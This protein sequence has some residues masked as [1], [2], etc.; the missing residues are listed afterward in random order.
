MVYVII[1]NSCKL[2][3]LVPRVIQANY[4]ITTF[5]F[6]FLNSLRKSVS[7]EE[8]RWQWPR[9]SIRN[10]SV[11]EGFHRSKEKDCRTHD[12]GTSG[13]RSCSTISISSDSLLCVPDRCQAAPHSRLVNCFSYFCHRPSYTVFKKNRYIFPITHNI[14][15]MFCMIYNFYT[16]KKNFVA[17]WLRNMLFSIQ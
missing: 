1:P 10:E 7:G 2:L 15:G 13:A 8:T 17:I 6:L 14:P 3:T 9:N 12:D 11:E 5:H 4:M 16:R